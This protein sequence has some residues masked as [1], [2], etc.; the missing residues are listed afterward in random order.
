MPCRQ[1]N[2]EL[3]EKYL[4]EVTNADQEAKLKPHLTVYYFQSG[5]EAGL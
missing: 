1:P 2:L 4:A 3:L 5:L